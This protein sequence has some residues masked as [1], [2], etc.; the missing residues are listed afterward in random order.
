MVNQA[1]NL[2]GVPNTPEAP[3]PSVFAKEVTANNKIGPVSTTNVSQGSCPKTCPLLN[4]GCYAENGYIGMT[5]TRRLN[6][7]NPKATTFDLAVEE[8]AAID[9]LSGLRALRLHVV[10]DSTTVAGTRL[11]VKAVQRYRLRGYLAKE[12]MPAVWTYTH[13]SHLVPSEVW[14]PV[15]VLASCETKADVEVAWERGYAAAIVV[16]EHASNSVYDMAGL[17]VIPCREQTHGTKCDKCR[18]CWD[19][20]KLLERRLVI[21][22][23]AHGGLASE[24]RAK[25]VILGQNRK[26]ESVGQVVKSSPQSYRRGR[27]FVPVDEFASLRRLVNLN[28]ETVPT[29]EPHVSTLTI[30]NPLGKN[31]S[32]SFGGWCSK[33]YGRRCGTCARR[34]CAGHL[35]WEHEVKDL[36]YQPRLSERFL[37]RQEEW[38]QTLRV[39]RPPRILRYTWHCRRCE[40]RGKFQTKK[41][42]K[43]ALRTLATESHREQ[44]SSCNGA[45]SL[46]FV[47]PQEETTER[48]RRAD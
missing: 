28:R 19:D 46:L 15:S 1:I 45:G 31:T 14:G 34:F 21:G 8:A 2:V 20:K 6:A 43:D 23:A 38:L 3:L 30:N 32:C 41:L 13:A 35:C 37:S 47:Q 16:T 33:A 17:K 9:K 48:S 29:T 42:K 40:K 24:K 7:A 10:G 4:N 27:S 18:L 12:E 5:T 36:P 11:L 44:S 26:P 22:F 39:G 25:A